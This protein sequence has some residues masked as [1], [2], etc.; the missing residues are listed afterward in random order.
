MTKSDLRARPIFHHEREAIDAHLTVVF[1][2]LALSRHLQN[3]AGVSIKKLVQ[4]L[5]TARSATI[6]TNGQRMTLAPELT[7][8]ARAILDRLETGHQGQWH[9]SG[10][11]AGSPG[12]LDLDGPRR[13]VRRDDEAQPVVPAREFEGRRQVGPQLSVDGNRNVWSAGRDYHPVRAERRPQSLLVDDRASRVDQR[14]HAGPIVLQPAS[15]V[16]PDL[17]GV[18]P[19]A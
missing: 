19:G 2:A 10:L 14:R 13:R 15:E 11:R 8:A 4:T 7:S 18:Q 5:R 12:Q 6:E 1:A 17:A 16:D 9:E 3:R